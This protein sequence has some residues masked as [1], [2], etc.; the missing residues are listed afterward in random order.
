MTDIRIKDAES[1][2]DLPHMEKEEAHKTMQEQFFNQGYV[3]LKD[4]H[5]KG[6]LIDKDGF[7]YLQSRSRRARDNPGLIDTSWGSHIAAGDTPI[8]SAMYESARE[9][10]LAT[11]IFDK[12][13]FYTMLENHPGI[14]SE[15]A[16]TR[17]ID[18]LRN[19]KSERLLPDGQKWIEPCELTVYVSY[20]DGKFRQTP[21]S[22]AGMIFYS[23]S[24]L[25]EEINNEPER[26]TQDL[27][28]LV[29]RFSH[30]FVPYHE[31]DDFNQNPNPRANELLQLY[32]L[33]GSLLN[34]ALRKTNKKTGE[35]GIHDILK[36]AHKKGE[37]VEHKH[38]HIR[39][40][41]MRPDGS[42]YM[43]QRS[44]DKGDNPG[45]K[46]KPVGGHVGLGDDY[47]AAMIHESNDELGIAAAVLPEEDFKAIVKHRP[48]ILKHQAVLTRITVLEN[49]ESRRI[50]QEE[51]KEKYEFVE[52]GDSA[53]YFGVYD[54]PIK[55]KDK[56]STGVEV[57]SWDYLERDSTADNPQDYTQDTRDLI[58]L[59]NDRKI[60]EWL[61]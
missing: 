16:V 42:F 58:K 5:A 54:G 30:L 38:R 29:Q 45:L 27:R 48:E 50:V 51:G 36:E 40:M 33:D 21:K 11:T 1:G 20:F 57:K 61:K 15:L 37:K 13:D 32:G 59:F 53:I 2:Y 18:N 6:I 4:F 25:E 43:Q 56:E 26:F 46:D 44:K 35:K 31:L 19:F 22:G 10:G 47:D 9:L 34:T 12:G 39:A 23:I 14:T 49:Y 60:L 41:I 17:E 3:R 52:V 55:F 24:E 7:L 8:T 28:K